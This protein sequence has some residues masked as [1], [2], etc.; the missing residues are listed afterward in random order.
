MSKTRKRN[1]AEFEGGGTSER[2][3]SGDEAE[4]ME[5]EAPEAALPGIH[6][7]G[8]EDSAKHFGPPVAETG[9]VREARVGPATD[10]GGGAET[11]PKTAVR[12]GIDPEIWLRA[13]ELAGEQG[14]T[15]DD[16]V[17]KAIDRLNDSLSRTK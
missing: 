16:Y 17:E 4:S 10:V 13:A 8:E 1:P 11:R 5:P 2:T 9:K 6:V 14:S 15:M 12:V 7:I 3:R